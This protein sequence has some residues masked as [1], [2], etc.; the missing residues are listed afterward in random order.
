LRYASVRWLDNKLRWQYLSREGWVDLKGG[1]A[2][3]ARPDLFPAG[4][5][6]DLP[7]LGRT[8]IFGRDRLFLYDGRI[9]VPV[10]DSG[11]DRLGTLPRVYDLPSIGRVLIST[12]DQIFEITPEAKIVEHH[13][14]FQ[15]EGAWTIDMVDWPHAGLAAVSTRDGIFI[16][17]KDLKATQVAGTNRAFSLSFTS[18]PLGENPGTGE[19]MIS[20]NQGLFLIADKQNGDAGACVTALGRD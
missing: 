15:F 7:T 12:K 10:S 4:L 16:L 5:I 8:L 14:P 3:I 19:L 1:D 13:W 17:V 11:S 2:G 18:K 9:M 6:K 20:G